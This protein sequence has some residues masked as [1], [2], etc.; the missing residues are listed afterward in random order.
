MIYNLNSKYKT[1]LYSNSEY[2]YIMCT[3]EIYYYYNYV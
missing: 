2:I 3:L 1:L